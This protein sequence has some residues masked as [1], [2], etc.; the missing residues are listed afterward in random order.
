MRYF[1]MDQ[2]GGLTLWQINIPKVR[3]AACYKIYKT[4]L[5]LKVTTLYKSK[6]V[7]LHNAGI[8]EAEEIIIKSILQPLLGMTI[9]DCFSMHLWKHLSCKRKQQWAVQ[10]PTTAATPLNCPQ[11]EGSFLKLLHKHS[12]ISWWP[13]KWPAKHFRNITLVF[14]LDLQAYHS[15]LN[16]SISVPQGTDF[17]MTNTSP[18]MEG[19]KTN[20]FSSPDFHFCFHSLG[21]EFKRK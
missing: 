1:R 10:M 12:D 5:P 17:Y 4:E 2:H 6:I 19:K 13:N 15:C 20:V 14:L 8:A 21:S 16:H 9:L 3:P 18:I 11:T 7:A